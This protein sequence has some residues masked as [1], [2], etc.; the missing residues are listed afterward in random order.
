MCWF[1]VFDWYSFSLLFSSAALFIPLSEALSKKRRKG[2]SSYQFVSSFSFVQEQKSTKTKQ[3]KMIH[4]RG[5]IGLFLL[6]LFGCGCRFGVFAFQ[7]VRMTRTEL[8]RFLHL[9]FHSIIGLK[10]NDVKEFRRRRKRTV[11]V[12]DFCFSIS[13]FSSGENFFVFFFPLYVSNRNWSFSWVRSFLLWNHSRFSAA[14]GVFSCF[15]A[16]FN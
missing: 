14:T 1:V 11:F 8:C 13:S 7:V 16:L 15:S 5:S 9:E 12:A 2:R 10:Q 3:N 4:P 6:F